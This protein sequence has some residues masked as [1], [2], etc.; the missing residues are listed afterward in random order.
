MLVF[1][2]LSADWQDFKLA[3]HNKLITLLLQDTELL[4]PYSTNI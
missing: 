2:L 4:S 1:S 3:R